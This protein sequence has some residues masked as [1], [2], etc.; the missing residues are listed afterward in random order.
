MIR[1]RSRPAAGRLPRE[2]GVLTAV[3]FSVA[4]GFGIVA[5]AIPVF[6]REFGVSRFA[7]GAVVAVFALMRFVF[8]FGSGGLVD[9][10]G[11]RVI[12][13]SGIGIVAVSSVLAGLA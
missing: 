4:V 13:A 8:A 12:L 9:R 6:A 1:L 7:A 5:P 10:F 2:V 3:S 11:E